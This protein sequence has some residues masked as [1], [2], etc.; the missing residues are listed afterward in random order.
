FPAFKSI[1]VMIESPTPLLP[2]GEYG[3][4]IDGLAADIRKLDGV[5]T[6]RA[7]MNDEEKTTLFGTL[8]ASRFYLAGY[9][10]TTALRTI[11]L[12]PMKLTLPGGDA[13]RAT[14]GADP[15]GL[16]EQLTAILQGGSR[17]SMDLV[18]GRFADDE[19]KRAFIIVRA[20]DGYRGIEKLEPLIADIERISSDDFLKRFPNG[21]K[22]AVTGGAALASDSAGIMKDDL[23]RAAVLSVAGLLLFFIFILRS[24]RLPL[25]FIPPVAVGA[26]AGMA[27]VSLIQ[28]EI[29]GLTLGFG[30]A[31][32]GLCDD[33]LMH[34]IVAYSMRGDMKK[35]VSEVFPSIA[36]AFVS[37]L[38]S[39]VALSF[40]GLP[41]IK[42]IAI[43]GIIGL[44]AAFF[45]SMTFS[46]AL[47]ERFRLAPKLT[48][49]VTVDKRPGIVFT[50]SVILVTVVLGFFATRISYDGNLKRLNANHPE[51]ESAFKRMRQSLEGGGTRWIAVSSGRDE[52]EAYSAC[53]RLAEALDAKGLPHT[54]PCGVTPPLSRQLKNLESYRALDRNKFYATAESAGMRPE[55]FAPFFHALDSTLAGRVK[56]L[57]AVS[58]PPSFLKEAIEDATFRSEKGVSLMTVIQSNNAAPIKVAMNSAS[59]SFL[60][61]FSEVE[62][63][64]V[65]LLKKELPLL[66]AACVLLIWICLSFYYRNLWQAFMSLIPPALSLIWLLGALNIFGHDV[67]AVVVCCII[68]QFGIG[69]DYAAYT[70]SHGGESGDHS[71]SQTAIRF[72][73]ASTIISFGAL[74]TASNP[75]LFVI[76]LSICAGI[77]GSMFISRLFTLLPMALFIIIFGTGCAS[78]RVAPLVAEPVTFTG[79]VELARPNGAVRVYLSRLALD[80]GGYRLALLIPPGIPYLIAESDGS[81]VRANCSISTSACLY[82]AQILTK[83]M[84]RIFD[85]ET[86]NGEWS[87]PGYTIRREPHDG[88][89]RTMRKIEY[90][91]ERG[92]LFRFIPSGG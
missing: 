50:V 85:G 64:I 53:E 87:G 7:G 54:A 37:T 10:E 81:R 78:S 49:A 18:D 31:L 33:Y 38:C 91:E 41:V 24:L 57:T 79:T 22:I 66:L 34:V 73:A 26:L 80:R 19:G 6:A 9:D 11:Q 48:Q 21:T 28:G 25:L 47:S 4:A 82:D 52:E 55:A 68:F 23:S 83:A 13:L 5:A 44:S 65:A 35:A 45:V 15:I 60:F 63:G 92:Y 20:R 1:T 3:A 72:S 77:L 71:L 61:D 62:N 59:G 42:E 43:L 12:L 14:I 70:L 51:V 46:V 74:L 17:G 76:G 39:L 56:P 69:L 90:R 16:T 40:S 8:F 32:I 89:W 58:L 29:H 86:G 30:I 67:N 75:A 27:G 88:R 84:K 36:I 2:S